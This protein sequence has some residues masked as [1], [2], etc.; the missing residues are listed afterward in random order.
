M[1]KR[2]RLCLLT[3]F[4]VGFSIS[5]WAQVER[6]TLAG[7]VVDSSGLNVPKAEITVVNVDTG[8]EFRTVTNDQGEFVAPNLIPGRYRVTVSHPGFKSLQRED[9]I[10]RANER[11]AVHLSLDVG[12]VT[13]TVD[14]RG[15]GGTV[16]E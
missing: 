7:T 2:E 11:L 15:D 4:I 1:R 10:V 6:G 3:L 14:V 9:L 8:V 16:A 12:V 5:A 13:Q